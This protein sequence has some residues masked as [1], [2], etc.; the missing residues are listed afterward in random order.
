MMATAE[1][2]GVAERQDDVG[3][4]AGF[5]CLADCLIVLQNLNGAKV[6]TV[7]ASSAAAYLTAHAI[8]FT[9]L[10]T[11]SDAYRQLDSGRI[12]AIVFDAP[13]LQNHL[14]LTRSTNETMVGGILARENYG[15]A[16]PSGSALRK[17]INETLLDIT[18]DGTYDEL[19]SKYFQDANSG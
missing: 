11:I 4:L 10:P 5:E 14:K 18:A 1:G 17:K 13:V 9:S 3:N 8:T 15:I 6:A 2:C 7:T 16:L 12:D 19:Y